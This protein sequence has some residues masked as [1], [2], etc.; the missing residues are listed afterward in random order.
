MGY[1]RLTAIAESYPPQEREALHELAQQYQSRDER[2]ILEVAELGTDVSLD[3]VT[4]LGL[5]PDAD[6]QLLEA[7]EL[8]GVRMETLADSAPQQALST[9]KGKYFEVLVRDRL[10]AGEHLGELQL[11]PGQVAK[12]AGSPTQPGWDLSI[13]NADGSLAEE[14]QL[15][16]TES[17]SY[18]KKALEK[19]PDIRVAAPSEI[20]YAS[21]EILGTGISNE[22]L[23]RVTETQIGE[24]SEGAVEDLLDTGAEMALD[25]IP[26]VSIA[27]TGVIE[28]RNLLVGRSTFRESL[29]RGSKRLGR[30]TAYDAIGTLLGPTGVALPSVIGLRMAEKRISGRIRLGDHLEA[31]TAELMRLTAAKH[32]VER[33]RGILNRGVDIDQHIEDIRGG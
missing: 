19:Y 17:M 9:I 5:E 15:K 16:A 25:S 8:S 14:I 26:F 28:G 31:K 22:Q 7:I 6:P 29:R 18:V 3:R 33:V 21:E 20:D 12:L 1:E 10:N 24:L 23:E 13:E 30:A 32:P 4:N 2:Q 27:M 11:E